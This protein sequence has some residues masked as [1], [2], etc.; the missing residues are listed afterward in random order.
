M[1]DKKLLRNSLLLNKSFL[2]E[3]WTAN[4]LISRKV[5]A[6]A[7][8]QQIN[9]LLKIIFMITV[10]YYVSDYFFSFLLPKLFHLQAG[11]IP[12][13][14]K[15]LHNLTTLKKANYL[16]KKFKTKKNIQI[17]LR[18]DRS[19]KIAA[20]IPLCNCFGDLLESLFVKR[21]SHKA[22]NSQLS[23]T[24]EDLKDY[25]GGNYMAE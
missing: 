13:S 2:H 16:N 23:D 22:K 14:S 5:L 24:N 7:N 12:I 3:L 19:D 21:S 1:F 10:N 18:Q 20:I 15:G 4:N 8:L 17:L 11:H 6:S 25:P 9:L